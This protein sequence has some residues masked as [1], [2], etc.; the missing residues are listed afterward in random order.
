MIGEWGELAQRSE[1]SRDVACFVR[2]E[3]MGIGDWGDPT[4][5]F[6]IGG[7][8][9]EDRFGAVAS[10]LGKAV[11]GDKKRYQSSQSPQSLVTSPQSPVPVNF[12]TYYLFY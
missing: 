4:R 12:V 2:T 3:V 10:Y 7:L 1:V 11:N 5:R 6:A 9:E 8:G